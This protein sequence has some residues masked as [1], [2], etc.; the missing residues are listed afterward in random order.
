MGFFSDIIEDAHRCIIISAYAIEGDSNLQRESVETLSQ[1]DSLG[2]PEEANTFAAGII[3]PKIHNQ[4]SDTILTSKNNPKKIIVTQGQ[5]HLQDT[6]NRYVPDHLPITSTTDKNSDSEL[7]LHATDLLK[8][9]QS[10]T[11]F[12]SKVQKEKKY[13]LH[14]SNSLKSNAESVQ[15]PPELKQ[16]LNRKTAFSSNKTKNCLS[17]TSNNSIPAK[18][19]PQ[20]HGQ[21]IGLCEKNEN[22]NLYTHDTITNNVTRMPSES[23][24]SGLKSTNPT[25]SA[26]KNEIIDTSGISK[27]KQTISETHHGST[28]PETLAVHFQPTNRLIGPLATIPKSQTTKKIDIGSQ[29]FESINTPIVSQ[30]QTSKNLQLD[31]Y[32]TIAPLLQSY[33]QGLQLPEPSAHNVHICHIDVIIDD[34]PKPARENLFQLNQ[35]ADRT[36]SLY[37]RGL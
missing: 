29:S 31:D 26:F 18:N 33:E 20:E 10:T 17:Q 16:P 27:T 14:I 3:N 22:K 1:D 8:K 2:E 24:G 25:Q 37:L 7:Q 6:P 23:Y 34:T 5:K 28:I 35:P 19:I 12:D 30:K 13:P 32:E 15:A 9:N 4:E 11:T 36:S 21:Q